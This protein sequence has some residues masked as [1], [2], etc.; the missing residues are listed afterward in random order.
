MTVSVLIADDHPVFRDGL[1]S[2]WRQTGELIVAATT[3]MGAEIVPL[4]ADTRP[5]VVLLDLHL[6]D[7]NGLDIMDALVEMTP[8]PVVLILSA[9]VDSPTVYRALE[10]GA[11]GY[12]EKAASFEEITQAVLAVAAGE[13]MI[14]PT[15][16]T[17][18]AS[19]IRQRSDRTAE[20][21]VLTPRELDVLRGC[22]DGRS[23]QQISSALGI[24]VSTV[25]SHLAHIYAKLEVPDR[26]A[27]VG[28]AFRLGLLS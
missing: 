11:S 7:I 10:S 22:A 26:A 23:V 5:D 4:V 20:Q 6:P 17:S 28:R 12:L 13:T 9:Y 8:S 27:A 1:A 21:V 24:S 15:V 18:L 2:Y 14:G 16:T 3:G 19:A 25:K